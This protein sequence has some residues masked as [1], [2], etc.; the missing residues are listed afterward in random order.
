MHPILRCFL[1]TLLLGILTNPAGATTV[2]PPEFPE[3][4]QGS[5][6][7]VHARV[8]GVRTEMRV[9]G[10]RELPY[11]LVDLEIIEVVAGT[12]P[13]PLVLTLL[14]GRVGDRELVVE[15]APRF[16]VGD[17]DV[18]FVSG[19]GRNI[20]PLYGMMHGRYPVTT[21]ANG[22]KQMRR[23]NK[24]LLRDVSEVRQPL[25]ESPAAK[26]APQAASAPSALT[27]GEFIARIRAA[28]PTPSHGQ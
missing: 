2:V 27:P 13:E 7:I 18:L 6:Y 3:L 9:R 19:N 5:D 17:E 12:P 10:A 8:T 21:D 4:V 25:A 14:G 1:A 11:T 23:S 15:G 16:A 22:T 28:R 24:A 26:A 20:H